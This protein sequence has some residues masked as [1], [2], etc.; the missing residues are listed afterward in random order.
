MHAS[1]T[2]HHAIDEQRP[3]AQMGVWVRLILTMTVPVL[4]LLIGISL[5]R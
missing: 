1:S 5:T 3:Q 4:W 2:P